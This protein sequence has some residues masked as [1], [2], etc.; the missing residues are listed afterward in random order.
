MNPAFASITDNNWIIWNRD[1][2]TKGGERESLV[3]PERQ[4]TNATEN[5]NTSENPNIIPIPES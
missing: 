3:S 2:H 1:K 5:L 4:E